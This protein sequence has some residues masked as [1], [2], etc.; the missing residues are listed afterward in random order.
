MPKHN[1]LLGFILFR[2][3]Q[4]V[5]GCG[6]GTTSLYVYSKTIREDLLSLR[7]N[8]HQSKFDYKENKN[9]MTQIFCVIR[10]INAR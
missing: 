9:S 2:I 4:S 5:P 7:L 1:P 3:H 10:G 6:L 8:I